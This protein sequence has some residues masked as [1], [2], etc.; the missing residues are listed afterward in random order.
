MPQQHDPRSDAAPK[1]RRRQAADPG[2]TAAVPEGLRDLLAAALYKAN[3][4]VAIV[5]A[6]GTDDSRFVFVNPAYTALTGWRADELIG[7]TTRLVQGPGTDRRIIQGV[8]EEVA[9]GHIASGEVE[10]YRKDGSELWVEYRMAPLP[11]ASG[12]VTHHV[13]TV[14]DVTARRRNQEAAESSSQAKT[15][16]LSRISHELMTPLNSLIG[17]PE[18]LADGHFGP[19]NDGQLQ[20]VVNVLEAAEQLRRLLRDLLDL[21]R[22][23][24]GRLQLD[25]SSFDLGPLLTDLSGPAAAAARRKQL[26]LEVDV[27]A[28]LPPVSG[29]P[30]RLKQVVLNLLDNAIKYTPS[31]GRV[32]L[33]AWRAAGPA[34]APQVRLS[35]ADSGIGIRE[36]DHER[37]FQMFEQV[38]P[39]LTRRHSGT[40]LGLALVKGILNLH[41]ARAWVESPGEG[42]G[43]T[44][45]VEIPGLQAEEGR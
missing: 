39:S 45:H 11:D 17:F 1:A 5:T 30:A 37:I 31:G 36:G 15:L 24:S 16:F 43:S 34:G 21:A 42:Q 38:D 23:E 40:G 13:A 41:G 22:L 10:I 9:A 20:A 4:A 6:D 3:E 26:T 27:A 8:R 19:L 32:A 29:D 14:R 7:K 2:P 35:V 44:F 33:R 28:G 18:M 25:C 12:R